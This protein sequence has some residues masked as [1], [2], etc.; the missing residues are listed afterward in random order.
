VADRKEALQRLGLEAQ[1]QKAYADLVDKGTQIAEKA[2]VD[3]TPTQR[4]ELKLLQQGIN[5][6]PQQL[7]KAVED[8]TKE[9]AK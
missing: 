9:A 3:L 4:A 5:P 7:E 1:Q 8:L 6:T 2:G